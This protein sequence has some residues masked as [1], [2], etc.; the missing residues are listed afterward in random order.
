MTAPTTIWHNPEAFSFV[1][2]AAFMDTYCPKTLPPEKQFEALYWT[3][4]CIE[5]ELNDDFPPGPAD[6]NLA[7]LFT[8]ISILTTD[9]F[10]HSVP[11]FL[12]D[13][14]MLAGVET[15]EDTMVMPR[16]EEIAWGI[17]EA[18]LICPPGK[19]E[20]D[21]FAPEVIGFISESL[22]AEGILTPPDVLRIAIKNSGL[23][24]RVN[25][26]FSDDPEMLAGIWSTER[27]KTDHINQTIRGRMRLL[28]EQLK[29]LRLKNG[30]VEVAGKLLA[31][32]GNP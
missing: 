24:E 7:R 29:G 19:D 27:E 1:L 12:H 26:E 5:M 20:Q 3:P 11:T 23:V 8:A 6:S 31:K 30:T 32:L 4:E 28:L 13:C 15:P 10:H 16:S 17:T 9:S 14:A 25:Y 21:P 2:L 22:D 18:M